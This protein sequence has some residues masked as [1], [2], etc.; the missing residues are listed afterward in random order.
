MP[1]SYAPEVTSPAPP[2]ARS[3]V[4]GWIVLAVAGTAFAIGARIARERETASSAPAA[5]LVPAQAPAPAVTA[6]PMVTPVKTT[7]A[8]QDRREGETPDYPIAQ[9]LPLRPDDKV[10]AGQG[11]LEV[12]AGSRDTIHIDGRL[13]GNGPILKMP[14]EPR[15]EPYEIRVKLRGEERVRFVLVKEGR[16]TRLRVAPPWS[17]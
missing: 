17:R 4:A 9:D 5:V 16:L 12:L 15:G 14:L 10:D 3:H 2:K 7:P 6:V 11:M 1:S 13:A 8:S